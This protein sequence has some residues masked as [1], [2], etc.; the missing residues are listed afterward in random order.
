MGLQMEHCSCQKTEVLLVGIATH[1]GEGGHCYGWRLVCADLAG[2]DRG[3]G[4]VGGGTWERG[5][6]NVRA[7]ELFLGAPAS[8]VL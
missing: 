8:K 1:G 4:G 6:L 7:V 2:G 3:E 5:G